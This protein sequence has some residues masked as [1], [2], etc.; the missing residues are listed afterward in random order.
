VFTHLY[1][2]ENDKIIE[3]HNLFVKKYWRAFKKEP[4]YNYDRISNTFI[5][6]LPE[7]K[8]TENQSKILKLP[9]SFLQ[10]KPNIFRMD[11]N[12]NKIRFISAFTIGTMYDKVYNDFLLPGLIKWNLPYHVFEKPNLGNW[13]INSRQRPLYI[14]EAMKMFPGENIVWI[15]T[16]AKILQYPELLFKIPETYDI[17]V[18]YLKWKEHYGRSDDKNKI[19]ILDGTS[20]YKN[21][22]SMLIFIDEWIQRSVKVG[23]NHR[24]VLDEMIKE[25]K[26]KNI[27]LIP[28][29]YCYITTK[30]DGTQPTIPLKDPII[31]HFQASR[32]ARINL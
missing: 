9:I 31:A 7:S 27:F 23:K 29:D 3:I 32:Q 15:D 16:D 19:E 6:L 8:P 1:N 26:D 5:N 4:K 11:N 20:Y 30:P 28:R 2:N 17:G 24:H 14:K 21:S 10:N 22:S 13:A 25:Q 12:K 18:N